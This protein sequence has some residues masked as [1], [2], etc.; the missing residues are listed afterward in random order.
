MQK[1]LTREEQ[2]RKIKLVKERKR[3]QEEKAK[4][5]LDEKAQFFKKFWGKAIRISGGL[6]FF[7]GGLV[8]LDNVMGPVYQEATINHSELRKIDVYSR[9]GWWVPATFYDCHI[10]DDY[11]ITMYRMEHDILG[12]RKKF[13]IGYTPIFHR[14]TSYKTVG[15]QQDTEGYWMYEKFVEK[16][17]FKVVVLPI[18][19]MFFGLLALLIPVAMSMETISFGYVNLVLLPL[20]TLILGSFTL[21]GS[22]EKGNYIIDDSNLYLQPMQYQYNEAK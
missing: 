5:K 3:Q 18:I 20:I 6:L 21:I 16:S 15:T 13:E 10:T 14:T 11:T 7:F 9:D 4:K 17:F 8:T 22:M 2:I 1:K 19:A 12:D